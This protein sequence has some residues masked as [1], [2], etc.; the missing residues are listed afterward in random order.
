MTKD[1]DKEEGQDVS[2]AGGGED[3]SGRGG[4]LRQPDDP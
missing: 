1:G 4:I 2:V 3:D